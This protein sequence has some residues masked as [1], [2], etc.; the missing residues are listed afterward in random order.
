M[1]SEDAEIPAIADPRL[2]GLFAYNDKRK[3]SSRGNLLLAATELFCR[4]GYAAVSVEDI[5]TQAG[6]SRVTFYR[7]FPGKSAVALELFQ[8]ATEIA[9][10]HMLAIGARDFRDRAVVTEWLRDFFDLNRE[11]R[12]ILRV[13]SQANVEEEEDFSQAVRPYVL[14]M[15]AALGSSIP[16]FA[17]RADDPDGGRSWVRAWL[18]IYTILDQSNHA[19]TTQSMATNPMMI[20]VLADSF[21][22]FVTGEAN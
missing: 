19:A 16:A 2:A 5:T 12:G 14:E 3:R 4:K 1:G 15:V 13:L 21:L 22:E 9:A 8:R 6:V 11:M 18:L 17:V 7:H 10:P 20:E